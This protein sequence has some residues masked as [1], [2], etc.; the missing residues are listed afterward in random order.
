MKATLD[1][2][3]YPRTHQHSRWYISSPEK[4]LLRRSEP[5]KVSED[6]ES[7]STNATPHVSQPQVI[8]T[9]TLPN[10][11]G[12]RHQKALSA[13]A[14][15]FRPRQSPTLP[16]TSREAYGNGHG[17][18]ASSKPMQSIS[19]KPLA[20]REQRSRQRSSWPPRQ[21]RTGTPSISV[22]SGRFQNPAGALYPSISPGYPKPQQHTP[23]GQR[24]YFPR[25]RSTPI[26][27]PNRI[28]QSLNTNMRPFP[29]PM[30]SSP[31]L[32]SAMLLPPMPPS[33]YNSPQSNAYVPGQ[34]EQN[35]D[36][37]QSNQFDSYANSQAAS[38]TPN[39]SDI[40]QNGSMFTQDANGYG[41]R[42]Y[43]NH[44]DPTHQVEFC[45]LHTI[46]AGLI[47]I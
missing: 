27:M 18:S 40:Q 43:S 22:Q 28:P 33:Q 35:V 25:A 15:E 9:S 29:S 24:E 5:Y 21:S 7:S 3:A 19:S 31:M 20:M 39:A 37:S 38:A 32:P 13:E 34:D 1:N 12:I 47:K 42:Y 10:D 2:G 6:A 41:P 45:P 23:K 4:P 8:T 14:S 44:T 30:Q 11:H 16:T 46:Y 26:E 36:Y 17:S